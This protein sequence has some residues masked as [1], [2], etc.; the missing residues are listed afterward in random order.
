MSEACR[1]CYAEIDTP[2]R[3]A[4]SGGLEL[5]GPN[6]ARK[7]K[8]ES[9]WREPLQ[10]N[11]AAKAAGEIHR[12]FAHSQSDVFEAY[13]GQMVDGQG[14]PLGLDAG[15]RWFP[16]ESLPDRKTYRPLLMEDV[17]ARLGATIRATPNLE[18]LLLTKRPENAGRMLAEMFGADR[19][20]W[21][22][23]IRVGTSVED[24]ETANVRLPYLIRL[25][26]PNFVSM[27]PLLGPVD[28]TLHRYDPSVSRM[29][30]CDQD[31]L[32]GR[33]RHYTGGGKS[34]DA[35]LG[36][37]LD[38]IIVGGESGPKARPMEDAWV[39]SIRDQCASAEVPFFFKQW[40]DL[41]SCWNGDMPDDVYAGIDASVN[42]A[43]YGGSPWFRVGK[44]RAGRMLD[45]RTWDE[46]PEVPRAPAQ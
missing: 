38:W 10:W 32:R 35:D 15:G 6:A 20:T 33:Q 22:K 41:M 12:V 11:R 19:S 17:R 37:K 31:L 28:L 24:Q 36:G 46:F 39:L 27:E 44:K 23:N 30:E 4:R 5:W 18:W 26:L 14:R 43:G 40:G 16:A 8:A 34:F 21:P 42:L 25:G 13:P 29:T 45:G 9:G 1:F 7:V 3:V 2:A